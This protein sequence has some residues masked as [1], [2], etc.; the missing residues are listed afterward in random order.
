[1]ILGRSVEG[2]PRWFGARKFGDNSVVLQ[3]KT[4]GQELVESP[5][6]SNEFDQGNKRADD[7]QANVN[8]T[9]DGQNE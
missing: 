5:R 1:M 6:Y 7:I 3:N 9:S 8:G 2:N 4:L